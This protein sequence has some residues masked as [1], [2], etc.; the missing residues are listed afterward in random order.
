M[1]QESWLEVPGYGRYEVSS[2]GRIRRKP[3][4]KLKQQ[5]ACS[6][7]K[8]QKSGS[9]QTVTLF[10]KDEGGTQLCVHIVVLYA[11]RGPPPLGMVARHLDDCGAHNQ[12]DNLCWGTRK[13]NAADAIR[14]G[15]TLR[16]AGLKRSELTEKDVR[17]IRQSYKKSTPGRNA[18]ALSKR[19]GV[20]ATT[21]KQ[22]V[23]RKTWTHIQ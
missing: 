13:Q 5:R 4:I 19:Y 9:Y 17:K 20:T 8:P 1:L 14:N 16:G 2:F 11:F 3:G 22:I 21:I 23:D 18:L 12:L 10:K 6:F 15:R 7:L